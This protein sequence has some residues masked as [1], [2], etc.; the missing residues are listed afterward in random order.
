MTTTR[1][2]R[3][4]RFTTY[5][6][7]P[8]PYVLVVCQ[9]CV[10][11]TF[12]I[13]RPPYLRQPAAVPRALLVAPVCEYVWC[14]SSVRRAMYE[15]VC[16][17]IKVRICAWKRIRKRHFSRAEKRV[18]KRKEKQSEKKRKRS[19]MAPPDRSPR[20]NSGLS[21]SVLGKYFTLR[22]QQLDRFFFF[23]IF[24]HNFYSNFV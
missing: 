2:V 11:C 23:I 9:V 3:R 1:D 12:P 18:W 21:L 24:T 14:D 13:H 7:V 20:P 6:C 15:S 10:R 22:M 4:N 8:A 17:R 19:D 5:R 16:Y